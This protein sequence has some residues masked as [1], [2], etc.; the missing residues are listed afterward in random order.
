MGSKFFTKYIFFLLPFILASCV[1]SQ[2]LLLKPKPVQKKPMTSEAIVDLSDPSV[3]DEPEPIVDFKTAVAMVKDGRRD[4]VTILHIGDSHVAGDFM[5]DA[6]RSYFQKRLGD[7]GRGLISPPSLK[8]YRATGVD[9]EFKGKWE[10]FNSRYEKDKSYGLA[11]VIMQTKR[12]GATYSVAAENTDSIT[13]HLLSEFG[14]GKVKITSNRETK[15]LVT[16]SLGTDLETI[17]VLGEKA[18]LRSMGGGRVSV[19]GVD[20]HKNARGVRYINMGLPGATG[21]VNKFWNRDLMRAQLEEIK[22]DLIIW[23]YGTNEGFDDDFK[24]E[25]YVS[26]IQSAF[27][28]IKV[29][30]PQA[31]WVLVGAPDGQRKT[32]EGSKCS[33]GW[34]RPPKIDEVNNTLAQMARDNNFAFFDWSKQMGGKCSM[35]KW[36]KRGHGGQ[37]H[38][39]FKISGYEKSATLLQRFL[40][41]KFGI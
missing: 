40:K 25:K 4:T 22:P 7:A 38:V 39:H 18:E 17:T 23:S 16:G 14:G 28:F 1:F 2:E 10:N 8:A 33:D 11:G 30:A 5:T 27:D 35:V 32:G 26:T 24:P 29:A 15:T 34:R 41:S 36:I 9:Q 20:L 19:L 12:A 21:E 6:L 37:D 31:D 3:I 13:F